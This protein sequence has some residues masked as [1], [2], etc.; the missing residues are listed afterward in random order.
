MTLAGLS[1]CLGL[2]L[3]TLYR[4]RRDYPDLAPKSFDELESWREFIRRVRNYSAERTRPTDR[5]GTEFSAEDQNGEHVEFSAGEE[6]KQRILRLRLANAVRRRGLAQLMKPE[7]LTHGKI[8]SNQYLAYRIR[9][10]LN[11]IEIFGIS[12][13]SA[14][15]RQW[16]I[17]Q[18]ATAYLDY[19]L[20]FIRDQ[21]DGLKKLSL[22]NPATSR[23]P[24]FFLSRAY[25]F[26]RRT[27]GPL[28][29]RKYIIGL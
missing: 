26:L 2:P 13:Y 15:E 3:R 20:G 9:S 5:N 17:E 28:P 12:T 1:E 4:Y 19:D 16:A 29:F 18:L 24:H 7:D 14:K 21:L 23:D 8:G 6:R 10:A 11:P 25:N 27:S 22:S